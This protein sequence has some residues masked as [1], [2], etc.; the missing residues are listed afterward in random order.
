MYPPPADMGGRM[1]TNDSTMMGAMGDMGGFEDMMGG[2]DFDS[3]YCD[4][5][6]NSP[7]PPT[8]DQVPWFC[9]CHSCKGT[10]G[11]KGDR[12]DRGLP[13]RPG[14]PGRRGLTGFPGRPGFMGRPG[15]KGEKGDEGQKGDR[16]APGITGVK[17]ERG[18][19]GEKGDPGVEGPVG[20]E[21]PKGVDGECP[22]FCESVQGP[23]GEPGLP[24]SPGPRGLAGVQG[25]A[26]LRGDKGDKGDMGVAGR[27]GAAGPKG[28]QG[29]DGDC[30]CVDG[31]Q[32]E[33]GTQGPKGEK[34]NK[35]DQGVG[36]VMG[37]V[38]PKGEEGKM[39]MMGLPGPC[40]PA[41]QSAFSAALAFSFPRPNLPVPFTNILYNRQGN[42]NPTL[43][44]YTA[45]V[46]GT[47]VFTYHLSVYDRVLKVGLF[48]NFMPVVKT[49]ESAELGTASQTVVLHM[50]RGDLVW[51]QVKDS[52]TNGAY[53][54]SETSST[55][56]G[57]LLQPD[58]CDVPFSRDFQ[59]GPPRGEYQWGDIFYPEAVTTP[60]P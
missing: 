47:Y 37:A 60:T 3:T 21:G 57:Y 16:G 54:S 4:M 23:P 19:K 35:G 40:T 44:V 18:F 38:G 28:E 45:P 48:Y 11:P 15:V 51:L 34:G 53:S 6:L 31:A 36:G 58:N 52:L 5:L 8:A 29:L 59:P 17:G 26:G 25:P 24:G 43:G 39:G 12:G 49:T 22:E 9:I 1:L 42:F 55:F 50:D 14:S 41:I 27:P 13:G 32:G 46:N 56:S 10:P 30:N 33:P 7:V 20:P 2:G